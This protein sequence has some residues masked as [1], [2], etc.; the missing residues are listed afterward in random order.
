MRTAKNAMVRQGERSWEVM[1][2]E[3]PQGT[4]PPEAWL[5]EQGPGVGA[6]FGRIFDLL[7]EYGTNV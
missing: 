1:F 4:R 3:T 2:Y 5:R 6:R 7:E